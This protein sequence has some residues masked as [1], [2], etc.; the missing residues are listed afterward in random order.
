MTIKEF[1]EG[2]GFVAAIVFVILFT[3]AYVSSA[4]DCIQRGG[5]F[6]PDTLQCAQRLEEK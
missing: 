5:A 6:I 4:Y 2:L 3:I 1:F